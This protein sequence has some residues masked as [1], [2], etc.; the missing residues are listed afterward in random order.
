VRNELDDLQAAL[1]AFDIG[2]AEPSFGLELMQSG[3]EQRREV[4]NQ[5]LRWVEESDLIMVFDGPPVQEGAVEVDYLV[6]VLQPFEKA[7]ASIAQALEDAATEAGLIPATIRDLATVRLRTTFAGSF[8]MA[9]TGPL[10][11]DDMVLP[12]FDEPARPLFD[13][14]IGRL[15]SVVE[16]GVDPEGFE[17]GI[18]EEVSDLGQRSASHL[19]EL[20]RAVGTVGS[21][22]EFLWADEG[23][24]QRRVVLS[25]LIASRL[26]QVLTHIES[27]T[28]QAP[29]AGRLVEASLPRRTF[30]IQVSEE[31]LIRGTVAA[32]V[33]HRIED[34]F[35]KDVRGTLL[36]TRTVS[37]TSE[38]HAE[39]YSL[40]D[41]AGPLGE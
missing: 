16:A 11:A 19:T 9:L 5:E 1:A 34:Y 35:G 20:A 40:L 33:A 3:L 2:A 41:F 17:Q 23:E 32:E 22:V 24:A 13:R 21:P 38:K 8:G 15:L 4:L 6:K 7:V 28:E 37:T 25:S 26:Q 14:A 36:V 30:G 10:A 27:T 29:I 18:I 12:L 39:K 31:E